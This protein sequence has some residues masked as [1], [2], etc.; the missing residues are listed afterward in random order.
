MMTGGRGEIE[1]RG[2]R[3]KE[4]SSNSLLQFIQA[5]YRVFRSQ[6]LPDLEAIT[7][8]PLPHLRSLDRPPSRD[9][10]PQ[11]LPRPG[12]REMIPK[13][14][15]SVGVCK[16]CRTSLVKLWIQLQQVRLFVGV[17]VVPMATV[18]VGVLLLA[19]TR[20]ET[21]AGDHSLNLKPFLPNPRC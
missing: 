3:V 13:H 16:L 5:A 11:G 19:A 12:Q 18:P 20:A 4:D 15:I 8:N 9:H 1:T 14:I 10:P 6:Y 17:L 7:Q 2:N 21:L